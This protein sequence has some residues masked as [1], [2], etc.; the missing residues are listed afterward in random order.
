MRRG[1]YFDSNQAVVGAATMAAHFC[2]DPLEGFRQRDVRTFIHIFLYWTKNAFEVDFAERNLNNSQI[3]RMFN[4][5]VERSWAVVVDNTPRQPRYR[6]TAA[7]IEELFLQVVKQKDE[8]DS[9]RFVVAYYFVRMY[10]GLIRKSLAFL[11]C[12]SP[13]VSRWVDDPGQMIKDQMAV[14]D[15]ALSKVRQ[16]AKQLGRASKLIANLLEAGVP[17]QDVAKAFG[18]LGSHALQAEFP[19]DALLEMVP[20]PLARWE[21]KWGLLAKRDLLCGTKERALQDYR[22]M[23]EDL[24]AGRGLNG[25]GLEDEDLAAELQA[26]AQQIELC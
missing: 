16:Q 9:S 17:I 3:A 21:L 20:E 12:D 14:V 24:L 11:D 18:Q 10:G 5:L 23:L 25:E 1:S 22:F 15:A 26:V 19:A 8:A 4:E 6:L 13:E 2:S 7:G